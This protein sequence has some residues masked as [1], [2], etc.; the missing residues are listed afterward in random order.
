MAPDSSRKSRLL[1]MLNLVPRVRQLSSQPHVPSNR[2]LVF[3]QSQCDCRIR[4][5]F[6]LSA[7]ADRAL[8]GSCAARPSLEYRQ[9]S[10]VSTSLYE[11]AVTL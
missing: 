2:S 3:M 7:S 9:R 6:G 5:P 8:S 4:W 1:P 10:L 11:A